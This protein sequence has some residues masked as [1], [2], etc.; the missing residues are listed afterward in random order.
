MYANDSHAGVR[1]TSES[2]EFLPRHQNSAAKVTLHTSG[3]TVQV[4]SRNTAAVQEFPNLK[5]E[6]LKSFVTRDHLPCLLLDCIFWKALCFQLTC[7]E[8][9]EGLEDALKSLDRKTCFR[10]TRHK[11]L[12]KTSR[13]SPF[14]CPRPFCSSQAAPATSKILICQYINSYYETSMHDMPTCMYMCVCACLSLPL[15]SMMPYEYVVL[16][17]YQLYHIYIHMHPICIISF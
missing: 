6:R 4:G 2:K 8:T 3:Q 5:A 13:C 1:A 15:Y 9:V 16:Y 7:P 14:T 11:A 17:Q 12:A 10:S